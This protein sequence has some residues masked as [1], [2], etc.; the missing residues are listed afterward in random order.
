[1]P[2]KATDN[3]MS[4]V[5]LGFHLV[6]IYFSKLHPTLSLSIKEA[7]WSSVDCG[8]E[9]NTCTLQGHGCLLQPLLLPWSHVGPG[10]LKHF[11]FQST[12]FGSICTM[13]FILNVGQLFNLKWKNKKKPYEG[14]HHVSQIKHDHG[15]N[16]AYGPPAWDLSYKTNTEQTLGSGVLG[17]AL[18][19]GR[20]AL[21]VP[22]VGYEVVWWKFCD[23]FRIQND[24]EGGVFMRK[25]GLNQ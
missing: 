22:Q 19:R 23:A 16:L 24:F 20:Q 8:K 3:L 13:S 10:W 25:R 5:L 7:L 2:T 9:E 21:W 15:L 11:T 1:M 14:Q 4:M 18:Q 17:E 12:L 6:P